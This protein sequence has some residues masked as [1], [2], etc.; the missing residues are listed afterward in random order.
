M[1]APISRDP[2]VSS[3]AGR[4]A[5]LAF[6][7]YAVALFALTHWPKLQL[8]GPHNTD[9]V[10]HVAV[11]GMWTALLIAAGFFGRILARR[12]LATCL[13][14]APVYAAIDEAL[15]AIPVLH[16]SAEFADYYANLGGIALAGLAAAAVIWLR[17]RAKA[18]H[19]AFNAHE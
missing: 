16:R 2:P 15:Q 8:P 4:A 13:V 12:N 11:F 1:N 7:G 19:S 6:W 17:T 9:K 14:I 18:D 5:R 3:V 10:V